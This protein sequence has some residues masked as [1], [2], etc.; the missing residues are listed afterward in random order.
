MAVVTGCPSE[1]MIS[2]RGSYRIPGHDKRDIHI[3]VLLSNGYKLCVAKSSTTRMQQKMH[4]R[5]NLYILRR[6]EMHPQSH[7][8]FPLP[9]VL[10]L[11]C[12]EI[13][14]KQFFLKVCKSVHHYTFKLI[15][16]PD[17]AI[18]QVYCLSFK[19]S[20]TCFEHLHAHHQ[21]LN[22]CSNSLWFT[23]GAW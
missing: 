14:R 13:T 19:Y 20:S 22:K 18:S 3:H 16:K 6:F 9:I 11:K 12:L 7:K 1:C 15:N 10:I 23:V 21:E 8:E 2:V 5:T 4:T 17:A